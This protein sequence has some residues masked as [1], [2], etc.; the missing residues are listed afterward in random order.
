MRLVMLLVFLIGNS[1]LAWAEKSSSGDKLYKYC[2]GGANTWD[3]SYCARKIIAVIEASS[4]NGRQ[5]R[6]LG[7]CTPDGTTK[8]QLVEIVR[9]WLKKPEC[10]TGIGGISYCQ[11]ARGGFS[12]PINQARLNFPSYNIAMSAGVWAK[13]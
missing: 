3:E 1:G 6:G 13:A 9:A 8:G 5:L 12:L 4:G 2:R 11:G 10:E 7:I